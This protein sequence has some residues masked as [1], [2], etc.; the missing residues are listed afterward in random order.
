V[1][2]RSGIRSD[3]VVLA[4]SDWRGSVRVHEARA[5][6]WTRPHLERRRRGTS[7]PVMDFLFDYYPYSPGRLHT[8]HPGIGFA[9]AG[10]WQPPSNA[11]VYRLADGAWHADPRTVDEHRLQVA[12]GILTGTQQRAAHFGCFGMHEWAMVYRSDPQTIRHSNQPLRMSINDISDVV[13]DVGLRCTH[14]DAFRFFTDAATPL[15][16]HVP[17][18]EN[19]SNLEQG[20]CIHANM[21][22]FKYSMWFQPF[23]PGDLVLDCFALAVNAR[24]IDMRASPYDLTDFGYEPIAVE[25]TQGRT[26]YAKSQRVIA[27]LAGTLRQRIVQVLEIVTRDLSA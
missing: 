13:D 22:L 17:T 6:E 5:R 1:T 2:S 21:D 20:G 9:L 14:I 25:S 18:R 19:Q 4:E 23:I 11:A 26:E 7:H 12:L 3:L 27:D 10:D 15:N 24:E 16:Q 8:W